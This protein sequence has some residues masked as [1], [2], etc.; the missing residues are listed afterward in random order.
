MKYALLRKKPKKNLYNPVKFKKPKTFLEPESSVQKTNIKTELSTAEKA[1]GKFEAAVDD[2]IEQSAKK[3]SPGTEFRHAC[4]LMELSKILSQF[5]KMANAYL[6]YLDSTNYQEICTELFDAEFLLDEMY[7]KS[8]ARI[9]SL[10]DDA[11]RIFRQQPRHETL[12]IIH[13]LQGLKICSKLELKSTLSKSIKDLLA[14]LND[15]FQK[16]PPRATAT[17]TRCE[18]TI[19]KCNTYHA[20][21]FYEIIGYYQSKIFPPKKPNTAFER[22]PRTLCSHVDTFLATF[23]KHPSL[24]E[25][26]PEILVTLQEVY[27]SIKKENSPPV[28]LTHMKLYISSKKYRETQ[29]K[30]TRPITAENI[31]KFTIKDPHLYTE[32]IIELCN[33]AHQNQLPIYAGSWL[34]KHLKFLKQGRNYRQSYNQFGLSDDYHQ[35]ICSDIY[36]SLTCHTVEWLRGLMSQMTRDAT[37]QKQQIQRDLLPLMQ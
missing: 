14:K 15:T 17:L 32:K 18:K 35:K 20:W 19:E 27:F 36:R 3:T 12:T 28:F 33:V 29:D 1:K 2:K 23:Q 16:T 8:E 21:Q 7:Y 6:T 22:I 4:Q 26:M 25:E 5:Q 30:M 10:Q 24:P 9:Q 31:K 34:I 13:I 37:A 11:I